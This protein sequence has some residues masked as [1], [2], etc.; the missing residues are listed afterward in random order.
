MSVKF[1]RNESFYIRDGWFQK[2]IHAINNNPEVNVFSPTVG[3]DYL[4]IG[5]NMV[6]G[7]KYWLDASGVIA[8]NNTSTSLTELGKLFLKY[9]PYLE[10]SFSWFIIH[11]NIARNRN[12]APIFNLMFNKGPWH[13]TKDD[14]GKFLIQQFREDE[15]TNNVKESYVIDDLGV[16]LRTYSVEDKEGNPEDNYICPL[17]SLELFEKKK[18]MYIRKKPK[19]SNLSYLI[20]YYALAEMY[21]K[22]FNIEDAIE[23]DNSPYKLFNLD[24]NLFLQYLSEIKKAGYIDITK[25]AGL[26]VVTFRKK[27][28][29]KQIFAKHFG[30]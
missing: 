13:F 18:E 25:T 10:S 15:A 7:L 21:K 4:G 3:V 2:A 1:K 22:D 23:N 27:L 11:Y 5:T 20:V 19:F 12:N 6:K 16:F 8:F 9:D 30:E 29:I 24:K 17:S 28:S 26:N 14:I